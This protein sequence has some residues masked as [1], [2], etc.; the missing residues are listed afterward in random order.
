MD[1]WLMHDLMYILFR[2]LE[3]ALTGAIVIGI[4]IFFFKKFLHVPNP[5]NPNAGLEQKL[6][7]IIELL[8]EKKND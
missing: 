1:Y 6:D 8:E 2:V 5:P 3:I 7:R 4:S